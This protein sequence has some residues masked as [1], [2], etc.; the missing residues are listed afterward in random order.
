MPREMLASFH[1]MLTNGFISV[2]MILFLDIWLKVLLC[3]M[4]ALKD[5]RPSLVLNIRRY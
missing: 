4:L 5:V 2:V 3:T 1:K